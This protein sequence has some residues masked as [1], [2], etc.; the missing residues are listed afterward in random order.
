MPAPIYQL[1]PCP[2]CGA[3]TGAREIHRRQSP[4]TVYKQG[5]SAREICAIED[6]A[7]R[8]CKQSQDATGEWTCAGEFD[9]HGRSVVATPE[10]LAAIDRWID[11]QMAGIK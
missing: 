5:L 4:R 7:N 6:E 8:M 9:R 10:S 1:A 3:T 2:Q 11:R